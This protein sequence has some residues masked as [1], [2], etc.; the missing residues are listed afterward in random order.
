V[1]RAVRAGAILWTSVQ[2]VGVALVCTAA[3][4]GL[5]YLVRPY[6]SGF[7]D[8]WISDALPLDELP[9]RSA[10]S[11]PVFAAIWIAVALSVALLAP[12]RAIGR[13]GVMLAGAV[14]LWDF[15]GTTVS[16]RV[17]RQ[18]SLLPAFG[19]A[20]TLPAVYLA[21]ALAGVAAAVAHSVRPRG[22]RL[23]PRASL[24]DAPLGQPS[25]VTVGVRQRRYPPPGPP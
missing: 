19:T 8:T 23:P 4:T 6:V 13:V 22:Q 16:L 10:V 21:A 9:G 1:H 7:A 5:L 17:V 24:A 14:W 18:E 20:V 2:T 11:L 15:A 12:T 3:A 25:G